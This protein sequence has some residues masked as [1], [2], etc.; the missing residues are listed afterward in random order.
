M[1]YTNQHSEIIF[2][3]VLLS[4]ISLGCGRI[5][6]ELLPLEEDSFTVNDTSG[7]VDTSS[8]V[9]ST[10][11]D[12]ISDTTPDSD[13]NTPNDTS[14][15]PP[16][17]ELPGHFYD[18][19][20]WFLGETSRH[21]VGTCLDNGNYYDPLTEAKINMNGTIEEC[22]PL[23]ELFGFTD[24]DSR[25]FD[26]A[27]G[28]GY[29]CYH[30]NQDPLLY[31]SLFLSDEPFNKYATFPQAEVICGCSEQESATDVDPTCGYG[32]VLNNSVCFYLGDLGQDCHEVCDDYGK[33]VDARASSIVGHNVALPVNARD[34][35]LAILSG[36]LNFDDTLPQDTAPQLM[37]GCYID[38]FAA[39]W[40]FKFNPSITYSDFDVNQ[41]AMRVC[42]CATL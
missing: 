28:N 9:D 18:D 3:F 37:S 20:C 23:F 14:S 15:G 11:T 30:W 5:G 35:C 12:T 25:A 10:S 32:G 41:D 24:T 19:V 13:T 38:R 22:A 6:F 40:N 2:R 7:V 21:C 16:T 27:V 29:G 4:L 26:D 8:G 39:Q 17:C 42:G 36:F 31:H 33:N 34:N 1:Q